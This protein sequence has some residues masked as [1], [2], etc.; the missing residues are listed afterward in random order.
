MKPS[1]SLVM[2][3]Y[4]EYEHIPITVSKAQD[5]LELISNDYEI[6][7]IND[8]STDGSEVLVKDFQLKN[9]R[10]KLFHHQ[11]NLG[12]GAALKTGF[13]HAQKELIIYNGAKVEFLVYKEG[14]RLPTIA[15]FI[16]SSK[17]WSPSKKSFSTV[18]EISFNASGK[19]SK[20]SI[21]VQ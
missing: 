20:V 13:T 1:I 9:P 18:G 6:I 21:R 12:L 10:I 11:K 7:L 17:E 19:K 5:E 16:P 2:P 4:N 8:A 15:T 14:L 3:F